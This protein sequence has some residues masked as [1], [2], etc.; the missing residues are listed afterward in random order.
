VILSLYCRLSVLLTVR[1]PK[2][3]KDRLREG[4]SQPHW[5]TIPGGFLVLEQT[6]SEETW[7]FDVLQLRGWPQY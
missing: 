4:E 5:N 3:G 6:Q 2:T 1:Y 7:L